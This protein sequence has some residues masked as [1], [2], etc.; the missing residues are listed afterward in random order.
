LGRFDLIHFDLFPSTPSF[1]RHPYSIRSLAA[2][3]I[4]LETSSFSLEQLSTITNAIGITSH[5]LPS[6]YSSLDIT[7]P[8]TTEV[9][10]LERI[11]VIINHIIGVG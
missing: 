10:P 7:N 11:T 9:E 3:F 8:I 4:C 6:I 1:S 2:I 5:L